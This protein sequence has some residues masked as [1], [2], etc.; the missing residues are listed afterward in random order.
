[1]KGQIPLKSA[2]LTVG[3]NPEFYINPPLSRYHLPHQFLVCFDVIR[4]EVDESVA[5]LC[6]LGD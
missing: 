4:V 5:G 3:P 2:K 6:Q 1:M